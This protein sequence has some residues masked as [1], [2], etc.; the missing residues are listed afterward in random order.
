MV[1]DSRVV[2]EDVPLT[3]RAPW[4][5]EGVVYDMDCLLWRTSSMG[6]SLESPGLDPDAIEG[7][8]DESGDGEEECAS[9]WIVGS[10]TIFHTIYDRD[11]DA[12]GMTRIAAPK[13]CHLARQTAPLIPHNMP[14]SPIQEPTF[15]C[16][17]IFWKT[18]LSCYP[19]SA[20]SS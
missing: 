9:R 16:R 20:M 8:G 19:L 10:G 15:R 13:P 4:L 5:A 1:F 2:D 6:V 14:S 7:S 17:R 18:R 12:A 11:A 3:Q